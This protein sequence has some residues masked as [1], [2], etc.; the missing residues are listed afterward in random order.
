MKRSRH[1][2]KADVVFVEMSNGMTARRLS[3]DVNKAT[4]WPVETWVVQE[5]GTP[6]EVG[7]SVVQ[8]QIFHHNAKWN[9]WTS[10]L[11]RASEKALAEELARRRNGETG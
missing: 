8:V 11:V 10:S 5:G 9:A 2:T 3:T 7:D 1:I 4:R 6:D